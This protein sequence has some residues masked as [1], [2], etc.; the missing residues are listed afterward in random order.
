MERLVCSQGLC[1]N[2]PRPGYTRGVG[3]V[4]AIALSGKQHK[5]SNMFAYLGVPLRFGSFVIGPQLTVS[6]FLVLE[7]YSRDKDIS[8][9][10][11]GLYNMLTKRYSVK[12]SLRSTR[13]NWLPLE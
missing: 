12:H 2:V 9:H 5:S 8:A 3:A 7:L 10:L 1:R 13:S 4:R 6:L 11:G